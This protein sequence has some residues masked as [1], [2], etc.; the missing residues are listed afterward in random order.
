MARVVTKLLK[1][2]EELTHCGIVAPTMML[3]NPVDVIKAKEE[4]S[5]KKDGSKFKILG[6]KVIRCDIVPEGSFILVD[7]TNGVAG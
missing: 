2:R 1:M 4:G 3:L 5:L 7:E 6:M